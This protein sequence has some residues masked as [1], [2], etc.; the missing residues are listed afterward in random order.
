MSGSFPA[1]F[2]FLPALVLAAGLALPAPLR[3]AS[4]PGCSARS[5]SPSGRRVRRS[6]SLPGYRP[7]PAGTRALY[8]EAL[9]G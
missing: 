6:G 4:R 9:P 3:A 1:R 8:R 7:G 2:V 5:R